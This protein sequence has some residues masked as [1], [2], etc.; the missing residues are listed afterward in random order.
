MI[1]QLFEML[2]GLESL[3]WTYGGAPAL[4][5]L[6][7]YLS[8]KSR[9]FQI[10]QFPE[11][12]K[13]FTSFAM[14]K[15]DDKTR[16]VSPIYAFFTSVGG[17]IG[18]GNIVGVCLAVQL[19]GPGAVFWMW[20]AAILGMLVKYGE[21][22]LGVKFRIKNNENS[23]TGGPM[24]F[25]QKV[26]G[27]KILSRI[28][29]VLICLYGIELYI[30]RTVTESVSIG[31]NLNQYAV[32][33]ALLFLVVG[34][35]KGGVRIVG[36]LC[37]IIIP[38]FLVGYTTMGMWVLLLNAAKIPAMLYSIFTHAFSPCAAIGAFIGT[39][40]NIMLSVR[41]GVQ[42]ACYSGD[43]GVGYASV[44]HAE[45]QEAVPAKQAIFG[46]V[47]IFLDSFIV[48]T[49]SLFLVLLTDTWHQ[50]ISVNFMVAKALSQYFSFVYI[51]WPCFI[52]LL[53]YSTLIAF[54]AAGR[55]SATFLSPRYGA[56]IFMVLATSLFILFSFVGTLNNCQ[57]MMA[58]VGAL[59]LMINLY[60]LFFL[61]DEITFDLRSHK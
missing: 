29:A 33:F 9:F 15:Q 50:N 7:F 25:L 47:D 36:R 44:V 19:G 42:R 59:L 40:S 12:I 13:I 34:I 38:A 35:G 31:W 60:G 37:S 61:K 2:D 22:Y 16:G 56:R 45:S 6:G 5:I 46:I 26:P 4:F 18:I 23:Y 28:A 57:S 20:I 43:I 58:I 49:M 55:R 10:R 48:C 11:V 54:F 24:I 14:K 21:I 52:F 41:H 53:G 30:F 8:Y 51:L 39:G 32:I 27:G 17:C 1:D 3:F